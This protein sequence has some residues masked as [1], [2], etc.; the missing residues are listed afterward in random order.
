M[1]K[2]LIVLVLVTLWV[3]SF[4]D[5]GGKFF[6][7]IFRGFLEPFHFSRYLNQVTPENAGQ[8]ESVE[9]A[10]D[11]MFWGMPDAIYDYAKGHGFVFKPHT[12]VWGKQQPMWIE[13]IPP[14]EQREEVEEWFAAVAARYPGIDPIDVVNEPLHAPPPYMEA[15]GGSGDTGWDWVVNAFTLA[16]KY[17]P[18]SVLL[19]NEYGVVAGSETARR[20]LELVLVLKER[21]LIDGMGIQCHAFEM[22][23]ISPSSLKG[24]LDFPATAG[25]PIY[26]SELDMTGDDEL[27][28]RHFREKFPII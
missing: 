22:D 20:F 25:L 23:P 27:K 18:E 3:V 5:T 9:P 7:N 28:L 15:L 6:G 2:L 10:R 19:L 1:R 16:R 8:W 21:D 11:T 24:A 4:G 14:E 12:L 17:F 26:V 13:F